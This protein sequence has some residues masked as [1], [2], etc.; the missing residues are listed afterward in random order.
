MDGC[1]RR[2]KETVP[3]STAHTASYFLQ[4]NWKTHSHNHEQYMGFYTQA[5]LTHRYTRTHAPQLLCRCDLHAPAGAPARHARTR[6]TRPSPNSSKRP[7]LH[8]TCKNSRAQT[9]A[10]THVHDHHDHVPGT[11]MRA[12]TRALATTL[13][14]EHPHT[15]VPPSPLLTQA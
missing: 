3:P 2:I 11:R 15:R 6:T 10:H 12:R 7:V 4:L 1:R 8:A 13:G 9:H 5:Q 14:R